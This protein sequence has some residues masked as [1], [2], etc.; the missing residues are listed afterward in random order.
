MV[1]STNQLKHALGL[2]LASAATVLCQANAS[3]TGSD[4]D[5]I[6]DLAPL[7]IEGTWNSSQPGVTGT[8]GVPV[9]L[10]G[11][12]TQSLSSL[13]GVSFASRGTYSTEPIVRGLSYDRV[14][15][16]L[17][18]LRLPN[19]SPTRTSAPINQ[20]SGA[21]Y[22]SIQI[23]KALPSLAS[24][25]PVSGGLIAIENNW[26]TEAIGREPTMPSAVLRFQ[27]IPERN[28]IH[29]SANLA[30]VAT[31]IGYRVSGFTSRSGNYTS[32]DG[33]KVPSHFEETGGSLSLGYATTN[34]WMHAVDVAFRE[35][36]F[37][38]NA[39]LPLDVMDGEFLAVTANHERQG[40][41]DGS[42]NFRLRYGFS[43]S[44]ST[45]SNRERPTKPVNV[46]TD[47]LTRSFHADVAAITSLSNGGEVQFGLDFN[48]EERLAI[49]KRG[50]VARDYIWPDTLYKQ[51]GAYAE[52]RWQLNDKAQIRV[53]GRAD[54]AVSKA[55]E[56]GKSAFGKPIVSLYS[57]YN[58]AEAEKVSVE[59]IVLSG[60]LL[61][62]YQPQSSATWYAGFGSSGQIPPPTERYR[63]FLNALG[64]GFE[65][66]NPTLEPER[67]WELVLGAQWERKRFRLQADVYHFQ[68]DDFIW[69]QAIGTTEGVLPFNP[70]QTVFGYR[71]VNAAFTGLEIQGEWQA[72]EH[73]RFPFSVEWV[74]AELRESGTGFSNGDSLPELP[75]AEARLS[76]VLE[77]NV[78]SMKAWFQWTAIL[79]ASKD[80]DL[81][82]LNPLY[83]DSK[84]FALHELSL[85]LISSKGFSASIRVRNL[86]D[87]AFTPY[88]SLPVSSIRPASG[89]LES[90][91]RIP[92]AGRE[93]L[94]SCRLA[95]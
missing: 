54:Y 17:N 16:T 74:D 41:P 22:R 68:I 1:I 72:T 27:G 60:N 61:L 19:G 70:P 62:S 83:A 89:D 20:F 93:F 24:G 76:A 4:A 28:S 82:A 85:Q 53:G 55:R 80:N 56:A 57:K 95:F 46:D 31:P 90:G 32:G 40:Q 39:A 65:L 79:V 52:S 71:N 64:G 34:Q 47:T 49:R 94:I 33:R 44:S 14:S 38:E 87:K 2:F 78:F 67:K 11:S 59:D 88:L 81:P 86:F 91:D 15:T 84:S 18:G 23:A 5:R 7:V 92:G 13:P 42:W 73:I 37:T 58:G 9:D 30:G 63:A 12:L 77:G 51:S 36:G 43:E 6:I 50:P 25:P 66:G 29:W 3:G 75:P 21:G 69:R 26:S 10:A 48:R 35:Q 8:S 45:L